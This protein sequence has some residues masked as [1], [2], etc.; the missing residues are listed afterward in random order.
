M[1]VK[2]LYN[3]QILDA[4]TSADTLSE[5]GRINQRLRRIDP[6][7]QSVP[8]LAPR[9]NTAVTSKAACRTTTVSRRWESAGDVR[10]KRNREQL[11][12][13]IAAPG[14][15]GIAKNR[16]KIARPRANA[17]NVPIAHD[18]KWCYANRVLIYDLHNASSYADHAHGIT[19][20][21]RAAYVRDTLGSP[22]VGVVIKTKKTK[23]KRSGMI[24]SL[25]ACVLNAV[26]IRPFQTFSS[27]RNVHLRLIT[28]DGDY[29]K[30]SLTDMGHDVIAAEKQSFSFSRWITS[31]TTGRQNVNNTTAR[32]YIRRWLDSDFRLITKC[33]AITATVQRGNTGHVRIPF[34]EWGVTA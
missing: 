16:Q 5:R 13:P 19:C 6:T 14:T 9:K 28:Q 2:T 22:S 24:G 7:W 26:K 8:H 12:A 30:L 33:F 15:K 18:S 25:M 3:V 10:A 27:V 21:R 31:I 20:A 17:V 1:S 32:R 4:P 11:N 23:L 34:S 29:E